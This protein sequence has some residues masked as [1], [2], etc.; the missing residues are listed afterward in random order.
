HG[1][2]VTRLSKSV[3]F[4]HLI[5]RQ[6]GSVYLIN[7]QLD[8][9]L[10]SHYGVISGEHCRTPYTDSL[11]LLKGRRSSSPDLVRNRDHSDQVLIPRNKH[12]R[13]AFSLL[14]VDCLV[15]PLIDGNSQ[16]T[17]TFHVTDINASPVQ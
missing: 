10:F 17:C 12:R 13:V 4:L 7:P 9:D 6:Q 11:Q 15:E 8:T 16:F 2:T 14:Q 1:D 5:L 3:D